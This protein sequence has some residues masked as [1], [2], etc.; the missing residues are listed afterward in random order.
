MSPFKCIALPA[1]IVAGSFL[2]ACDV[3]MSHYDGPS[4]AY[5]QPHYYYY[6]PGYGARYGY[7]YNPYYAPPVRYHHD[8]DDDHHT[9][10]Y[11]RD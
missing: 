10:I 8:Y 1:L 7:L 2:V 11:V 3:A 5:D 4:Y 9:R 6:N